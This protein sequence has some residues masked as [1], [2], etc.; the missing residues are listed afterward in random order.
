MPNAPWTRRQWPPA[1]AAPVRRTPWSGQPSASRL[2][3]RR[4][5]RRRRLASTA[6]AGGVGMDGQPAATAMSLP[7]SEGPVAVSA[8]E[9]GHPVSTLAALPDGQRTR[10]RC[11][12]PWT[13]PGLR[14]GSAP[15]AEI[16]GPDA[17]T[18]D[19]ACG[20]P[21]P[22]GSRHGGHPRLRQGQ[23]DTAPAARWTAG[24]GTVH[25]GCRGSGLSGSPSLRGCDLGA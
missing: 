13:A 14:A 19:A 3:C 5:H 20:Q 9:S 22:A 16:D 8:A 21:R 10:R 6:V 25:C 2:C 12:V 7:C 17:W 1:A 4:G 24:S 23:A 15:P 18:T 11:P